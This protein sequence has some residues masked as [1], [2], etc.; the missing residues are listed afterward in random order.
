MLGNNCLFYFL[1]DKK[2]HI[3]VEFVDNKINRL[4]IGTAARSNFLDSKKGA[5]SINNQHS[6]FFNRP[7]PQ[8]KFPLEK[9]GN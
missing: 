4:Q 9:G 1:R 2:L 7:E 5:G 8:Y 3:V 6:W